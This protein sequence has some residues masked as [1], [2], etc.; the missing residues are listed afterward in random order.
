MGKYLMGLDNGGTL[1]KCALFDLRGREVAATSVR[2]EVTSPSPGFIERDPDA[3]WLANRGAIRDTM[4][5]ADIDGGEVVGVA[6]CGYGNGINF[7]DREGA[8][9]Y[10]SIVSNDI[11]ANEYVNRYASDGTLR[12]VYDITRQDIWAAQ[13][14]ALVPWFRDHMPEVLERTANIQY[15][16]DYVRYKL[17]GELCGELTDASGTNLFDLATK[18][19]D[20]RLFELAG[21]SQYFHLFPK[22]IVGSTES[23][24]AVTARAAKETGLREG[25]P[26]A[27]GLFDIDACAASSGILDDGALCL[28]SGTWTINEY[29]TKDFSEGLGKYST[30]LS[31][32]PGQYLIAESSP[33]SASNFDWYLENVYSSNFPGVD[34]KEQYRRCDRIVAAIHPGDSDLVFVPYLF[35]SNS[36]PDDRAAFFNISSFYGGEHMLRAVYEGVVFSTC[37]H[38]ERLTRNRER[39]AL[40]R[41]SGGVANSSVWAQMLADAL[42]IRL[43]IVRGSELGA[44]G[45][46][47]CAGI[48]TGEFADFREASE[49]MVHLNRA[50]DPDPGL[51]GVYADK[52]GQFK[53]AIAVL[54]SFHKP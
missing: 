21:I 46:A 7:L 10:P 41:L 45:A 33:T 29:I 25:T 42:Q 48:C 50:Y 22:R 27:G 2:V 9:V 26:V 51:T 6:A 37:L 28:V 52:F 13:P 23:A 30:T 8:P 1:I 11:R 31:Y 53:K 47:M 15:I 14:I 20:E 39:F 38:V 43:E 17:T 16:K 44:L 4:A 35:A 19:Y 49:R 12:K 36:Y 34:R 54:D 5:K 3:I 32:I 24:G 18:R 40:G